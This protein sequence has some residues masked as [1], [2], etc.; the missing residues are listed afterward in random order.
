MILVIGYGNPLRGDDGVGQVAADLLLDEWNG[1]G[2]AALRPANHPLKVLTAH[3]LTPELA[4]SIAA[5]SLVIFIDAAADG[6]P[7]TITAHLIAA[8]EDP[9]AFTHHCTPAGLLRLAHDWYGQMPEGWLF[10][11]G[12]VDFEYGEALS[13][14]VSAALP[15]LLDQIVERIA[16]H[17]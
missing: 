8:S 2:A 4:E 6:V 17:G 7:G 16:A 15:A 14:P 10:S 1:M 12:G 13:P 5:A 9:A 3:Q 11:I